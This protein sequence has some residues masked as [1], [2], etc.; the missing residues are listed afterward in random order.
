MHGALPPQSLYASGCDTRGPFERF[1][2]WGL[3]A[4]VIQKEAVTVMPSCSGA[5]N[6]VMA[7]SSSFYIPLSVVRVWVTVVLREL[8]LGW[9]NKGRL[10]ISWTHLI[11]PSRNFVEVW[12]RSLFRSTYLGKRCASYSAPPTSRKRKQSNKVSPQTFQTAFVY[13]HIQRDTFNF[14]LNSNG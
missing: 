14:N 13:V 2:Y 10:K 3:C 11:I 8:I 1:V 7:W 5:G 12:W 9:S 4:A 6:V